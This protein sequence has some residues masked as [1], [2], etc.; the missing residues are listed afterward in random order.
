M[1]NTI[2]SYNAIFLDID[3]TLLD[4]ASKPEAV[5]VPDGLVEGL[6]RLR[7]RTGGALAL[8]SG[9]A[10]DQ[11][12]RLFPLN[13]PVAAEHGAVLR[14]AEGKL[15]QFAARPV[16]Y[17]EWYATLK[18]ETRDLPGVAIEVKNLGLVVHYR[19]APQW[20]DRLHDLAARLVAQ[21]GG[22]AMLL[23]AHMAFELRPKGFG[24]AEALQWFMQ[25]PP[26]AGKTPIFVGDDTTDEPAIALASQIGGVGMHV[27]RDF[28]GSAQAVRRWVEQ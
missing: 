15:H 24:K 27:A 8:I 10:L 20:R 11:I 23:T 25:A 4:I 13:L 2:Q 3:G 1:H 21:A 17:D 26:F 22:E 6:E 28:G 7:E 5:V 16:A 12:D 9:R 14:D 18:R 19:Q